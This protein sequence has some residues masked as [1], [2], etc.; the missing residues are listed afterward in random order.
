MILDNLLKKK[1][2]R[3]K[4]LK[5]TDNRRFKIYLSKRIRISYLEHD[6]YQRG[7]PSVFYNFFDKN[8]ATQKIT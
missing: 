4:K 6:G 5:E 3:K 7:L 1:K 8:S 2:K